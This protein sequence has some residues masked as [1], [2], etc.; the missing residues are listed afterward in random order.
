ML[1][2]VEFLLHL[3]GLRVRV[4]SGSC[5]QSFVES[6]PFSEKNVD[7]LPSKTA[8]CYEDFEM[9]QE[10]DRSEASQRG[11]TSRGL[12]SLVGVVL[13][14]RAGGRAVVV[15]IVVVAEQA[16]ECQWSCCW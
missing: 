7:R 10:I 14:G 5:S 3:G 15:G 16:G 4:L 13:L 9:I 6:K 11:S 8:K 1:L 12:R 2:G